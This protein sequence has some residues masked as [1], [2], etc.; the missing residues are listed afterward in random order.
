MYGIIALFDDELNKKIYNLWQELRDESISTYAFEVSNRKPHITIASYRQ[1]DLNS[2]VQ[3]LDS[4]LEDKKSIELS[5]PS[6]GS[7]IGTGALFYAPLVTEN[8]FQFHQKFHTHFQGIQDP[9]SLYNPGQWIPHCT[10]AN[11]L[12]TEKLL[13]A[14]LY[15]T[16]H[17][18]GLKG[19]IQE[20]AII[21]GSISSEA[22]ILFSKRLQ[23]I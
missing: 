6:L 5:F 15:C 13:E 3:H 4:Y 19:Q 11:R 7:F 8:L 14:F 12:S 9:H 18:Q 16:T 17:Y 10:I 21:D 23:S 22:P 20:I 1:L 2:F